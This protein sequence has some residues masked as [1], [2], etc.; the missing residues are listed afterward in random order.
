MDGKFLPFQGPPQA[1]FDG[2]PLH[3]PDVHRRL[4][5]FV[6]LTAVFLGLIH[7]RVGVFDERL[8]VQSVV[9]KDADADAGGDVKVMVVDGVGF[10]H[11]LKHAPRRDGG[12]L[13]S[14]NFGKQHHEFIAALP[15]YGVRTA[16]TFHQPLGDGLQKLV[17]DGMAQRVVDVLEAIQVQK[18]D[19]HSLVVTGRH[20]DGLADPVVQQHAIGQTRSE[21]R[22]PRNG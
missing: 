20:R 9:G 17:P 11:G 3:R 10:G 2:L 1:F 14:F 5:E 7:G 19:C 16:Y 22:A 18:Q 4:E 21:N 12:V 13:R 6:A 15:A 8:R